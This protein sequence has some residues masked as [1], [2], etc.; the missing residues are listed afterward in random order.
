MP[1]DVDQGTK[2]VV[3]Y[4]DRRRERGLVYGFRPF[5]DGFVLY[6]PDDKT[7]T[8]GKQVDFRICKAIYFV[9]SHEGNRDFKENKL[10]LPPVLPQGRKICIDY[11]DG[12]RTVGITEGF[13][14]SRVGFFF[15]PADPKS[16]NTEIFVVTQNVQEIRLLGAEPD[17]QDRVIRPRAEKGIFLPEKR[18][19]AVQRVLRGEPLEKV[20]K[21]LTIAPGTLAEWKAKFLTGGPQALGVDPPPAPGTAPPRPG[22]A[23]K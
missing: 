6:P 20:A 15:L 2:V 12:E 17:G 4:L 22:G 21:E 19:E 16:N 10:Q 9:R 5:G 14:P 18:V 11:P 3:A 7:R 8:G 1:A 13:N 23:P